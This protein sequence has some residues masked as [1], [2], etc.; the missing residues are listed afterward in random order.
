MKVFRWNDLKIAAI[1]VAMMSWCAPSIAQDFEKA[2]VKAEMISPNL[3]VL[4]GAG[5]N[6][7]VSVGDDAV[8]VIDDQYAQ[9]APKIAAVYRTMIDQFSLAALFYANGN[10]SGAWI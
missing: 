6:I 9:M 10:Y 1:L 7:G 3:Y 5:G 8:F 4:F 2:V